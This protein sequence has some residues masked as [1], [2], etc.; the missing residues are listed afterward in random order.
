MALLTDNR[1]QK[2]TLSGLSWNMSQQQRDEALQEFNRLV[3]ESREYRAK[4]NKR[5]PRAKETKIIEAIEKHRK[6]YFDAL[7]MMTI[8]RCPFSGLPYRCVFDPWGVDGLWWQQSE[9]VIELPTDETSEHFFLL[10][11]AVNLQGKAPQGGTYPALLGP[12]IPF[13]VPHLLE[14]PDSR[15]IISS[16]E[17]ANGYLAMPLVYFAKSPPP[18][19]KRIESWRYESFGWEDEKGN[20]RWSYNTKPYEFDLGPWMERQQIGWIPTMDVESA[21]NGEIESP[22]FGS[23]SSYPLKDL[24]GST[25]R[26]QVTGDRLSFQ[27]ERSPMV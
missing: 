21:I 14:Q 20:H 16:F 10:Q 8:S 5:M 22:R 11:G 13:V 4:Y 3:I 2:Q 25:D 9:I 15:M 7:P 27:P 23:A 26:Q 17:M 1:E 6:D 12:E 24:Q 18:E 19:N